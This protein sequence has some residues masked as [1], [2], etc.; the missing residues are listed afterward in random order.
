MDELRNSNA[1]GGAQSLNASRA[2]TFTSSLAT[3]LERRLSDD[4]RSEKGADDDEEQD[5]GYEET[6]ITRKVKVSCF[7]PHI[8]LGD[9]S[10]P[11]VVW[12]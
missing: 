12:W 4:R 6:V 9:L 3:E 11:S 8:L 5:D 1:N 7:M 2:G 10:L